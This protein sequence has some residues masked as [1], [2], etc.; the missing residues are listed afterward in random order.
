MR[1]LSRYRKSKVAVLFAVLGIIGCVFVT[2]KP[3]ADGPRI[4]AANWLPAIAWT[5][6]HLTWP[7]TIVPAVV[8]HNDA[9]YEHIV[10]TVW[11]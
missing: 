3:K 5:V 7:C 11:R 8:H 10:N 1:M 2:G 6:E 4:T 9:I